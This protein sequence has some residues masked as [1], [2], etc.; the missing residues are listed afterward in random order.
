MGDSRGLFM[1]K[2][3]GYELVGYADADDLDVSVDQSTSMNT[4]ALDAHDFP[5]LS[6]SGV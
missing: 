6:P 2:V 4:I 3:K 5:S 1:F